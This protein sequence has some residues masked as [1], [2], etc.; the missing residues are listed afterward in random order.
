MIKAHTNNNYLASKSR[1]NSYAKPDV[2]KCHM[3]GESGHKFN[4]CPKRKQVNMV[5]YRDNE[6]VVVIEE[7][8]DSD[9]A[10]EYGDPI[11]CIV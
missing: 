7:A 11:A 4:E 10:E 8:S 9:F 3:C 6:G 1:E 5:N 2:G